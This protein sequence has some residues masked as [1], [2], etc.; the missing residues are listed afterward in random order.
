M[1]FNY[2][3]LEK[4]KLLFLFDKQDPLVFTSSLFLF[5]FFILL[6][7]YRISYRSKNTRIIL[8]LLFS[9]FF[10]YKASGIYFIF[11]FII[12]FL[13]F[14]LGKWIFAADSQIK[15]KAF[16]ISGIVLNLS[17]LGY[18]KY[19]NFFVQIYNDITS[20][21]INMLD[22]FLPIGI[23]FY[24]FKAMSYI[25]DIYLENMEPVKSLR[26]FTLYI[27][28]FPTLLAGPIERASNFLPQVE[29]ENLISSRDVGTAVFLIVC[30]L[31]K[32]VVIADYIGINFVD[33]VF[34]SPLRFT[35]VENLIAS[36]AYALQLFADFSG[37]TDMALG[38]SLLLGYKLTDNFYSPYKAL[39]IADFWR[40]WH[41]TL[42][43]WLLDYLFKPLQMKFR[44]MKTFGNALALLITF[45]I[46]GIWHGANWTFVI[47]GAIHGT[48]MAT[49]VF[50]RK[51]RQSFYKKTGIA[52]R[53]EVK[54][55]QWLF[56][57]NLIVFADIFFRSQNIKVAA[58]MITQ[59]FTFFHAEVF[60]QFVQGY[61]IIISLIL[62]GYILHFIPENLKLR[63]K[64]FVINS[65]LLGQAILLTICIWIAIQFRFA[66]LQP[67]LYFQF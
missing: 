14:F 43:S 17:I 45:T 12:S 7:L 22:I 8:L 61:K 4:I 56:T 19:T 55:L 1:M 54:F 24:I 26:D 52:G 34:D 10:Y 42:S 28:Y 38:I 2:L 3:D 39:S 13:N 32:K 27:F 20:A 50:T 6:L 65:P 63:S 5:S 66:D 67:F 30:G 23:S 62:V 41:I 33:R 46:I 57:F 36:Y 9:V 53:K 18:F 64:E 51:L 59:I 37:Y 60:S 11:L 21:N 48:Y 44:S 15:R 25:I 40:R 29:K 31:L 16:L 35:G 49:S 47:F 58:E